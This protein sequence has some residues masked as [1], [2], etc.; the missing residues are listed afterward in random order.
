M[1]L[2]R[3]AHAHAHAHGVHL[4]AFHVHHGLSPNA[5]AWRDH[6]AAAAADLGIPFD[7][8]AVDVARGKS[9]IEAAARTQRYAA[10]GAMCRAHG[11]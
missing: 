8:R 1:V 2:L 3:L 5:D 10:L 11:A 7:W 4:Y 6:C 9:G